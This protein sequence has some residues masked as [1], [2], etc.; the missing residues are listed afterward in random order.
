MDL[1]LSVLCFADF[2]HFNR[3]A[4]HC[5][6]YVACNFIGAGEQEVI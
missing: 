2:Q 3:L 1:L 4:V 5:A 6:L